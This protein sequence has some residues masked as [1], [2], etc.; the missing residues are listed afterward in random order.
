L[1]ECGPEESVPGVQFW[2]RPF[3]FQHGELLAEGE[4]FEGVSLRLRMNTRMAT[5][6]ERMISSTKHPFNTPQ[7]TFGEAALRNRKLLISSDH[8][9]VSADRSLVAEVALG[10]SVAALK[11]RLAD[12]TVRATPSAKSII[13]SVSGIVLGGREWPPNLM[14][15]GCV[16]FSGLLGNLFWGG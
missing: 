7:G 12:C 14:D 3:P 5:K 10:A 8:R 11:P 13:E 16:G 1:A 15:D 6:K 4:D 9:L 2:P